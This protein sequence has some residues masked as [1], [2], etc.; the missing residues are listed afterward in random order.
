MPP[1][2]SP[3][4]GSAQAAVA[5]LKAETE[6]AK[7]DELNAMRD[8]V[9]MRARVVSGQRVRV[10]GRTCRAGIRRLTYAK[11]RSETQGR[12]RASTRPLQD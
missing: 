2:P 1:G 10:F 3:S 7:R 8:A 11:K 4:A 6:A 5:R 12:K 9:E